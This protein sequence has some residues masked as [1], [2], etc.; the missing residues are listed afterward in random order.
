MVAQKGH[1]LVTPSMRLSHLNS[2]WAI[3][4]IY[5]TIDAGVELSVAWAYAP[6]EL[7]WWQFTSYST[8][9]NF[10]VCR[11]DSDAPPTSYQ[12]ASKPSTTEGKNNWYINNNIYHLLT[13]E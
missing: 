12:I 6:F 13:P 4:A 2:N 8:V 3:L 9:F 7:L 11:K 5:D 10:C 1:K